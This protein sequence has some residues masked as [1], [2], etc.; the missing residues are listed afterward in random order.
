MVETDNGKKY[1]LIFAG[2]LKKIRNDRNYSQ[3]YLA[4]LAKID[5]SYLGAVERGERNV[6][7]DSMGKLADAL[8]VDLVDLLEDDD[9]SS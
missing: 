8:G 1:R 7:I 4:N 2:N 3:E 5:R 9:F 6:S